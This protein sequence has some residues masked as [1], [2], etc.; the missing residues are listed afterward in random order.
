MRRTSL[1]S[2]PVMLLLGACNSSA[3][4]A[5]T[6]EP[7]ASPASQ[8]TPQPETQPAS[9][10]VPGSGTLA[11]SQI[12]ATVEAG[13]TRIVHS[14]DWNLRGRW[15]VVSCPDRT[16]ACVEEVIDATTGKVLSSEREGVLNLPPVGAVP[17]SAIASN[18]EA[19]GIGQIID[20]EFDDRRW[21][22]EVRSGVNR[23]EFYIDPK[24]GAVQRCR[25]SLCS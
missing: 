22:V 13:G 23:A 16:R 5:P 18:V 20:L 8:P 12:L 10:E 2:I 19:L 11:L 3:P 7:S 6:A 9:Q 4:S 24:T 21:N 15:E 17:A 1:L 25:G 14:A